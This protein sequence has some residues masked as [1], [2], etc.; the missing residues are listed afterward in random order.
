MICANPAAELPQKFQGARLRYGVGF[1]EREDGLSGCFVLS[2]GW[3]YSDVG[4]ARIAAAVEKWQGDL[5][6]MQRRL[7]SMQARIET[8]RPAPSHRCPAPPEHDPASFATAAMFLG[9]GFLL[10]RVFPRR[11]RTQP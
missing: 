7:D 4:R 2:S 3:Y 6:A 1:L 5:E 9:L 11:A 8:A 10:G